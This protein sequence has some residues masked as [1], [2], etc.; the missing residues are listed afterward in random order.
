MT[1]EATQQRRQAVETVHDVVSAMRAIA[2]GRIQG[3]QRT[4]ASARRYNEVVLRALATLLA[5]SADILSR[6]DHRTTTLLVVTSEQPLCGAFNLNVLGFAESRWGEVRATGEAHLLVVGQRG[7]RQ[8]I[9]RGI[10]P[11]GGEPAATSLEGIHDLVKRLANLLGER[12]SAGELGN[13]RVIFNRYHSLTEQ[14]PTEIQLL[15]LDLTAI[16]QSAPAR[17]QTFQRYLTPAQLLDGLVREYLFI[18]LYLI[19][20]ESFASEQ[21]SRLV[22][23]DSSTRSTERM[24]EA[25]T[26][27][28]RRERQGEITRQVLELIG[29]RFTTGS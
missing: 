27:L 23:M 17:S 1:W 3:A 18:S 28:E 15:P 16:P 7:M 11:E 26:D 12:H 22:A 21:A 29:A 24:L 8:L 19:A 4:L 5:G 10:K 6:V 20:A 13:L 2:A 25:L 9:S 14:V